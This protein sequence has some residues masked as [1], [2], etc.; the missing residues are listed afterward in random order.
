MP[1]NNQEKWEIDLIEKLSAIEHERWA[2]WQKYV[3]SKC[4][5]LIDGSTMI[6]KWAVE[7][8][9]RQIETPYDKLTEAEKDS[10]RR[11]V[12]RY[13]PI[14]RQEIRQAKIESLNVAEMLWV[15]LANVSEGDWTKQ[16]KEWQEAAAKWRDNYLNAISNLKKQ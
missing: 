7:Q 4:E 11:E 6:P 8:W 2:D 12:N 15:V 9:T 1:T 14:L 13:F 3:F 5:V 16:T 10:D